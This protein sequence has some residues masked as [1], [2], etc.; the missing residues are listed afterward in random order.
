MYNL[1]YVL[2]YLSPISD[3]STDICVAF[4]RLHIPVDLSILVRISRDTDE[5]K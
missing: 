1:I 5:I 2:L 4:F 3:P